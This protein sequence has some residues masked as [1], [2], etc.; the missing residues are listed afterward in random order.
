MARTRGLLGRTTDP[1][2]DRRESAA[3][4]VVAPRSGLGGLREAVSRFSSREEMH[5][6]AEQAESAR[7]GGRPCASLG[8]RHR[9]LVAGALRS[10]TLRPRAGTPALEAEVFD[11]SGSLSVVWLGRREIAGV[12]AGRR[13]KVEGLVSVVDGHAV[14]YNPRYELLPSAPAPRS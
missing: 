14:M 1:T 2:T 12:E 4:A 3:P 11:G 13:I 10:V 8:D 9:V 5:C 7:E 6:A